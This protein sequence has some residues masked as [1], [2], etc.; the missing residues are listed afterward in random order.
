MLTR[1]PLATWQTRGTLTS[2]LKFNMT[3][4]DEAENEGFGEKD[5][6]ADAY[7]CLWGFQASPGASSA[8]KQ[9]PR[10]AF[11]LSAIQ[12]ASETARARESLA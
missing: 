3:Q 5:S 12:A 7:H 8:G 2:T 1:T 6:F 11:D 9:I 10:S 4:T